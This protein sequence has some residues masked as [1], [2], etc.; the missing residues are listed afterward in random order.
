MDNT[1][2]H[3]ATRDKI[4]LLYILTGDKKLLGKRKRSSAVCAFTHSHKPEVLRASQRKVKRNRHI[5]PIPKDKTEQTFTDANH[6]SHRPRRLGFGEAGI[7]KGARVMKA[8]T[9]TK[10]TTFNHIDPSCLFGNPHKAPYKPHGHICEHP[11]K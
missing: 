4:M 7:Y 9:E 2:R 6:R 11:K 3:N 5:Y 8:Q 1:S 10:R